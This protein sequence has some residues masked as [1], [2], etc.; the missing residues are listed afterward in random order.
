MPIE[1]V[2][3]RPS[4]LWTRPANPE[5]PC[6]IDDLLQYLPSKDDWVIGR[7]RQ[8]CTIFPLRLCRLSCPWGGPLASQGLEPAPQ[9]RPHSIPGREHTL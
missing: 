4:R 9:A 6:N 7:S 2:A 8:A 1:L 3:V 5:A